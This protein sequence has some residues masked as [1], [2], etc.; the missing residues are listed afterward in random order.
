MSMRTA[1][2]EEF[3]HEAS[4]SRR[5]LERVPEAK[6]GWRPHSASMT[7]GR[8]AGHIAEIPKWTPAMISPELDLAAGALPVAFAPS[9]LQDVLVEL[10]CNVSDFHLAIG[11]ASDEILASR[12]VLRRGARVLARMTRLAAVRAFVLNH[13]VHH[14]GQLTVYLRQ[15]GVALP[16]IYGP[17]ADHREFTAEETESRRPTGR[18]LEDELIMAVA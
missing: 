5:L 6:L 12:F 1:L 2:L 18:V 7:L 9:R 15:L 8:L 13:V 17:T 16:Q 10:G 11:G 3:A 14:R 4:H